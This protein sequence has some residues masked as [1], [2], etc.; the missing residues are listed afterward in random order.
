MLCYIALLF[1]LPDYALTLGL[2]S[3]QAASISAILNT[4]TAIGYPF[5]GVVSDRYRRIE[6][7]G[8]LTF[9]CGL[10]YFEIWISATSYGVNVVFA[11][12]SGAILGV[13][14]VVRCVATF[15]LY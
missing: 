2:S 9:V 5:I 12:I 11:L 6:V 8:I 13:F 14:W 3:G 4:G 1:S 10:T 15:C 7:A